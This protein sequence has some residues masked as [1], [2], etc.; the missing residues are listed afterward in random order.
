MQG[1]EY[2]LAKPHTQPEMLGLGHQLRSPPHSIEAIYEEREQYK[3]RKIDSKICKPKNGFLLREASR[4]SLKAEGRNTQ[5]GSL[6]RV[7]NNA[8]ITTQTRSVH[9]CGIHH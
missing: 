6:S 7:L 9:L 3:W 2:N 1:P 8:L 5:E 4:S